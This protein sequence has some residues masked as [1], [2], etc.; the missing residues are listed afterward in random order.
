[1][2]RDDRRTALILAAGLAIMLIGGVGFEIMG[3]QQRAGSPL[4]QAETAIEEFFEMAGA[5]PLLYGALQM[6][7]HR[8]Q[9]PATRKDATLDPPI[10]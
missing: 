5:S 7:P 9:S 3:Y 6:S 2:W 8:F 4:Y 10:S 1:M